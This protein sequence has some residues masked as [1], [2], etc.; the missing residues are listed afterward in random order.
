M[1]INYLS[2]PARRSLILFFITGIG[3]VF[4]HPIIL[5][6][7]AMIICMYGLLDYIKN[8][9]MKG[10]AV[11]IVIV[12]LCLIGPGSFRFIPSRTIVGFWQFEAP[13]VSGPGERLIINALPGGFFMVSHHHCSGLTSL[14]AK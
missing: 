1:G 8:R 7:S 11:L 3:L 9:R 12:V 10:F 14:E 13:E 6:F 4:G 2:N 5:A